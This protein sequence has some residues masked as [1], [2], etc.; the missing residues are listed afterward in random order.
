MIRSLILSYYLLNLSFISLLVSLVVFVLFIFSLPGKTNSAKDTKCVF[1]GY[2]RF[3]RGHRCYS[4]DTNR[5]FI[6]ADVTF[7]EDSSFFS[8]AVRPFALDVLSIPLV[9]PSPD[10][11]SPPPDVMTRPLQVYTRRPR[12]STGPRVDSSLMSQSSPA[13]IPQPSDDL[14]IAIRKGTCSTSNPHPVYNFLSFH[15]LSLPYFAFVFTLSSVSAPKS[16]SEALSHPG[17]KQAMAEEMDALYFNDTW[18]LVAL[19]HGKSPIGCRWVY[20]MKVGLDDQIDQLK[21]RLVAKGYT[22]QYGSDYYDTFSPVAKIASVR[23]LLSMATMHSWHL[24]QLDI[25]NVF[26]HGDLAEEVYLEQPPSFV[27]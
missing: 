11:P 6:S 14:P 13:P 4:P 21:A 1:L 2:S 18:E 9:L 10:F 12:P 16:T 25:M 3:Q 7:F 8:S 23:L 22:Q 15:H 27:A 26:L 17:W 20:T 5:Y 24:F 19:P